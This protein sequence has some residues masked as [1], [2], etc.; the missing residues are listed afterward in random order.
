MIL[1]WLAT[2]LS[3]GGLYIAGRKIIWC[4]PMWIVGSSIFLVQAF[5]RQDWPQV[6]LFGGYQV[7]NVLGWIKWRRNAVHEPSTT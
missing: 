2:A 6:A 7:L 1:G 3:L 4:W 5:V